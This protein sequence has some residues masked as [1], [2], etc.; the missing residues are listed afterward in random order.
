LITLTTKENA[1]LKWLLIREKLVIQN[2]AMET[3][4]IEKLMIKNVENER[5]QLKNVATKSY[6]N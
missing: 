6:G 4:V 3:M 2:L 5:C 1:K